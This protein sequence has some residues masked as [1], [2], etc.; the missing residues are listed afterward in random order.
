M[1]Q[2]IQ[3]FWGFDTLKMFVYLN[4]LYGWYAVCIVEY[5]E[6]CCIPFHPSPQ[7]TVT[8]THGPP[9]VCPPSGRDHAQISGPCP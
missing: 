7:D 3:E 2:Y 8:P 5:C 6:L 4:T 9:L 1:L